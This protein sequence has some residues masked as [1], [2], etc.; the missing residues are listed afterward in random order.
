MTGKLNRVDV[1]L[2]CCVV[3][4][5]QPE[6]HALDPRHH[7]GD[8]GARPGADLATATLPGFNDGA[9]GGLKTFTFASPATLT[10]GTRYAF[11]FRNS[12]TFAERHGRLHVQL[13]DHR[14]LR[15][16]T[17][18]RRPV[19]HLDDERLDLDRRHDRRRPRPQLRHLRQPGLRGLRHVRLVAQGREPGRRRA[20]RT[21]RPSASRRTTPAGTAVKFQV[22]ASNASYGPFNYVGPDGTAATFFTT[23]GASLSQFDGFRYLRYKAFLS[24]TNP[25]RHALALVGRRVLHTT[26]AAPERRPALAVAPATGTF[27]GTTTLSATLTAGGNGVAGASVTFTL[28]GTSVGGATTNA[29]GR[30][31][32][33]RRQ[34]GGDQRGLVPDGR[35]RVLR[36]RRAPTTR[37]PARAR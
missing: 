26:S 25:S 36:R 31:D 32:A 3:H 34:P 17:R 14:V 2:F 29:S 30:R 10:A 5:E 4:R 7:G 15:T 9:A 21:G 37:A 35:R 12:A 13:R 1:E 27:G 33:R 6:H 23:S 8:A 11:I 16:R 24:T 19:R 22:A 28:N 18:T 20:R